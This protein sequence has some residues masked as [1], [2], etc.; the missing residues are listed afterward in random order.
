MP[1]TIH[2]VND[3]F[4]QIRLRSSILPSFISYYRMHSLVLS[5]YDIVRCWALVQQMFLRHTNNEGQL[6]KEI[7]RNECLSELQRQH[8]SVTWRRT[9]NHI[10]FIQLQVHGVFLMFYRMF[11]KL[12]EFFI[13]LSCRFLVTINLTQVYLWTWSHLTDQ[14]KSFNSVFITETGQ[15]Q[16][17]FSKWV[18]INVNDIW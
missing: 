18:R 5:N 10:T 6:K 13:S 2:D 7:E 4:S 1:S 8:G 9:K 14:K 3:V 15:A 11:T 16:N 17:V 12:S